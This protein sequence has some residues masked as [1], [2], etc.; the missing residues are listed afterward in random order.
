[1]ASLSPPSYSHNLLYLTKNSHTNAPCLSCSATLSSSLRKGLLVF[2]LSSRETFPCFWLF[3]FISPTFCV[4]YSI[5]VFAS[6]LE[7]TASMKWLTKVSLQTETF[8]SLLKILFD[9]ADF[10]ISLFDQNYARL[11][12]CRI[13]HSQWFSNFGSSAF[14]YQLLTNTTYRAAH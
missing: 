8:S 7:P 4:I 3:N 13:W 6:F 9:R 1:M 2:D 12:G 14:S 10:E 5:F 11:N